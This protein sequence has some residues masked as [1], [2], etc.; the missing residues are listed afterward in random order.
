MQVPLFPEA[1]SS[2]AASVDYLYA[3]L[4]A[5]TIVMTAL[6]FRGRLFLRHQISAQLPNEMPRGR[7]TAR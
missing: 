6:I 1:A 7:F 5:V 4:S 2:M 3:Y